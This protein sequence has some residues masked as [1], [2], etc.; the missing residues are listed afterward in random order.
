MFVYQGDS[1]AVHSIPWTE[2]V[3]SSVGGEM[4]IRNTNDSSRTRSF[5]CEYAVLSLAGS[6][7][8]APVVVNCT[9]LSLFYA[10][11]FRSGLNALP[12]VNAVLGDRLK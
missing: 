12:L 2:E 5:N 6:V 10:E 9:Y 4:V 7:S 11:L 3:A 1:C 8:V